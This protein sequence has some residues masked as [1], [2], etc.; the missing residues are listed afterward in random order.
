MNVSNEADSGIRQ[1][2]PNSVC[3]KTG[4]SPDGMIHGF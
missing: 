2:P 4:S 1:R 3:V